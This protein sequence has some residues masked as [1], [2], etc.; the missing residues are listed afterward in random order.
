MARKRGGT[1]KQIEA[2]TPE[3][4]SRRD[5]STAEYQSVAPAGATEPENTQAEAER[6]GQVGEPELSDERADPT[7][8]HWML[9]LTPERR[10]EALQGFVNSVWELRYGTKA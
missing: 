9:G 2:L 4:A 7:L 3:E 5:V 1:P 8:I 6:R 10:L